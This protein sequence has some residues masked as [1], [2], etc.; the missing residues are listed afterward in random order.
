MD[1]IQEHHQ[2]VAQS[3]IQSSTPEINMEK[4][5]SVD[6]FGRGMDA[7]SLYSSVY[8]EIIAYEEDTSK[9][10][11]AT[12]LL[13]S[14][15]HHHLE[16]QKILI[17][18]IYQSFC[19]NYNIAYS[20]LR[21][22]LECH[23]RGIFLNQLALSQHESGLWKVSLSSIVQETYG[24]LVDQLKNYRANRE[25]ILDNAQFLDMVSGIRQELSFSDLIKE[26]IS[27][28][29]TN[30]ENNY[31]NFRNY[32]RYGKLSGYAHSE[33]KTHD[34][35]RLKKYFGNDEQKAMISESLVIPQLSKEYLSDMCCVIDASMVVMFNFISRVLTVDFYSGFDQF[36]IDLKED[37]RFTNSHLNYCT[38]WMSRYLE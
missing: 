4:M 7:F 19:G 23:M 33:E 16:S 13:G 14:F 27:W 31:H 32:S 9:Q 34:I 36:I 26:L 38:K 5:S 2:N 28:E 30:P 3:I 17:N 8:L 22:F 10:E 21:S 11:Q 29:L 24:D 1:D 6:N 35:S 12:T 25:K 37:N 15:N 20:L 18:S